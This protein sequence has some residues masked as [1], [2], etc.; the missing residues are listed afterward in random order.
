MP[1]EQ[2]Y[3]LIEILKDQMLENNEQYYNME[4]DFEEH[5]TNI[6]DSDFTSEDLETRV[7]NLRRMRNFNKEKLLALFREIEG[8][9]K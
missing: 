2:I 6:V 3:N 1:K 5:N 4:I 7:E 8:M 9:V